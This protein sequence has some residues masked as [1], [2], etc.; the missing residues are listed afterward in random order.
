MVNITHPNEMKTSS[1]GRRLLRKYPKVCAAFPFAK[2]VVSNEAA[3]VAKCNR[4]LV[5]NT[6]RMFQ[7]LFRRYAHN[8][9]L[10]KVGGQ[11]S[12]MGWETDV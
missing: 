5:R 9:M 8:R 4:R 2:M 6:V 10:R 11:T 7:R 1:S 12:F 3:E